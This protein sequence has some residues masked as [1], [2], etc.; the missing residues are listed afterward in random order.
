MGWL[1]THTL[2]L[3]PRLVGGL[4]GLA[5]AG[6]AL[7]GLA[8]IA[9]W[10]G[11]AG[12]TT[13]LAQ[14]WVVARA[15]R[16]V[17]AQ[18]PRGATVLTLGGGPTGTPD[19]AGA[20]R[21]LLSSDE[22]QV[23]ISMER[24]GLRHVVVSPVDAGINDLAAAAGLAG[25]FM[26]PDTDAGAGALRP[27]LAFL[28]SVYGRLLL[29]DRTTLRTPDV[30]GPPLAYFRLAAEASRTVMFTGRPIAAARLFV[31]VA[32]AASEHE[33]TGLNAPAPPHPRP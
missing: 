5:L 32:S 15:E 29:A 7:V 25:L 8:W 26:L 6:G 20:V 16:E 28:H 21:L 22:E 33:P 31:R 24:L 30:A 14:A 17:Q 9:P 11:L 23:A 3:R 18:L 4:L 19:R 1:A 27:S 13:R 12:W 10:L 2:R